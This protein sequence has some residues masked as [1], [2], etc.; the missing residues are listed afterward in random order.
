MPNSNH[1][2]LIAVVL[3]VFL[4]GG[5]WLFFFAG[6]GGGAVVSVSD[7]NGLVEV[8]LGQTASS[9]GVT[10]TPLEVLEDSRCPI[11]VMCIQAGRVRLRV[12][13]TSGLGRADQVFIIGEPIATKAEEIALIE[14]KPA[15]VSTIPIKD[16]DYRF[17]FKIQKS[18]MTYRNASADLVRVSLPTPGAVTGKEFKVV[19]EARGTWF[20]EASF[21][22]E[23]LAKNGATLVTVVAQAQ[24]DWMTTDFVPFSADIAVPATYIGP[25]TIVLHKDNPSGET[26]FDASAS[27]PITIEY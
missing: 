16:S 14:V 18:G 7:K 5:S 21:P 15:K 13:L 9:L 4:A 11:D 22:I 23:V 20:F 25:A 27:F 6:R 19:G 1:R 12:S 2:V 3:A 26:A 8:G 17:T 24:S 10:I